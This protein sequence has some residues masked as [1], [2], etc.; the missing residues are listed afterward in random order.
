MNV[1][2]IIAL[3]GILALA[4]V[5]PKEKKSLKRTTARTWPA[6]RSRLAVKPKP[7]LPS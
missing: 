4:W 5:W 1:F 7:A 2:I 6:G 3:V